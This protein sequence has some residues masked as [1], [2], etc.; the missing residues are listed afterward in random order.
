MA[1]LQATETFTRWLRGLNDS[2]AR[3]VIVER[4]QRVA[5]GLE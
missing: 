4:L 2:R 3:G 5:R 1:I